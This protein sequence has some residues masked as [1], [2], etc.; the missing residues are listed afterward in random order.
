MKN[1]K[2]KSLVTTH[3][4]NLLHYFVVETLKHISIT[5]TSNTHFS[6]TATLNTLN[7]AASASIVCVI[8][9]YV[10]CDSGSDL[11][12]RNKWQHSSTLT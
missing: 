7:S 3:S 5:V 4:G 11:S 8:S 2:L 10:W 12:E 6:D 1:I 9:R